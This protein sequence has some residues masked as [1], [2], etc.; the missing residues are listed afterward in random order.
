LASKQAALLA[1]NEA[2]LASIKICQEIYD[3]NLKGE[4]LSEYISS[5][6]SKPEPSSLISVILNNVDDPCN[7]TASVLKWCSK[8]EY[9]SA[10]GLLLK[11]QPKKQI[12]ALFEI[13]KYFNNIKFPKVEVKSEKRN[14]IELL[15]QVLFSNDIIEQAGFQEWMYDETEEIPG[16]Q[17]AVIQT[18][19]F[20]IM[21]NDID[22]DEEEY[23]DDEVDAVRETI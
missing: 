4:T 15:F 17:T 19:N 5:L 3:K 7:N 9:G 18:T 11:G 23:E 21:L 1:A 6:S 13:Q 20:M 12:S 22:Q 2:H 16:K 10:L 14:L 8:S